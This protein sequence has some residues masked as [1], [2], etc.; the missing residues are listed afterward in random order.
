M[1]DT[2]CLFNS[3]FY[4]NLFSKFIEMKIKPRDIFFLLCFNQN[5]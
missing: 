5:D 4:K 3:E 2:E 1:L